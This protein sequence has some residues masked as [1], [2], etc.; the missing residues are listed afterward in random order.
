MIDTVTDH[1]NL[2]ASLT[3]TTAGCVA[4]VLAAFSPLVL[5]DADWSALDSY[6]GAGLGGLWTITILA[7][8][9]AI[10]SFAGLRGRLDSPTAT[11][12]GVGA[13]LIMLIVAVMWAIFVEAALVDELAAT[14]R[15]DRPR[16][17]F[18]YHRWAVVS[19]A[20][21]APIASLW[22]AVRASLL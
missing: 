9:I 15:I 18:T 1:D 12:V 17:W 11:A 4:T 8:A 21:I 10:A 20:A 19:L 2:I 7:G 16:D 6:V 14:S 3:L 5:L 13:G 22:G